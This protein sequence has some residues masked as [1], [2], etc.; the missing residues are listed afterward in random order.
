MLLALAA[1]VAVIVAW[2]LLPKS[3]LVLTGIY[4]VPAFFVGMVGLGRYAGEIFPPFVAG[5]EILRRW[6]RAAIAAV[7]VACVA[8]QAACVY[9]AIYLEFIP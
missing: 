2:R 5:G 4:L 6:P 7:F 3:W 1:I 9:W 8:L